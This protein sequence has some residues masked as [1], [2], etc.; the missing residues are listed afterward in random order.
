MLRDQI[1]GLGARSIRKSY[2]PQLQE[3]IDDLKKAKTALEEKS[4]S[5]LRTLNDLEAARQRAEESEQKF[6]SLFEGITDGVV[7]A[8]PET[9]QLLKVNPTFCQMLGYS[10]AELLQLTIPAI[11][12]PEELPRLMEEITKQKPGMSV[13]IKNLP[14]KRRD[15]TLVYTDIHATGIDL[16]NRH[17]VLGACRDIT[18]R[19]QAEE[20]LREREEWMRYI[21]QY[22][23]SAI[24]V[25][26]H[27]LK[28]IFVSDRFLHDYNV[29]AHDVIGKHHYAVFPELP[30]KWKVMHQRCLAGAIEKNDDDLFERPDG[31]INYNRW[32]CRPWFHASGK[33]GGIVMYTEVITERKLAEQALVKSEQKYRELVENANSIILRWTPDGIITYLNEFGLTFFGYSEK[34]IVGL[35]VS[36]IIVPE[37]ESTGR[38]LFPLMSDILADPEKFSHNINE[39]I[40]RNGERVWIA[41]TN[42][43]V[44]DNEGQIKEILS[45]GS[46]VTERIRMEEALNRE[47]EFNRA[48]VENM[49]DA[50][51]ACNAEFEL[52]LFNRAAR[53]W[54]GVDAMNIPPEQWAEFYHLFCANGVT[55]MSLED[56]PLAR[57][58]HGETLHDEPMVIQAKGQPL[59]HILANS[60]PF[61]D[62]HGRKLGAVA[63]M[64]DITERKR[65]EAELYRLNRLYAVLSQ[66]NQAV[67]HAGSQHELLEQICRIA[68]EFGAFKMAWV[69]KINPDTQQ[70]IPVAVAGD[71]GGYLDGIRVFADDRPEGRGPIGTSIREERTYVSNDFHSDPSTL[72]WR[73]AANRVGFRAI[74]S[75]PLKHEEKIFG[76][77]AVYAEEPDCFHAKEIKLLEEV[78]SDVSFALDLLSREM[79]RQ[80]NEVALQQAKE[81]AEAASRAK[82]QFIAV[83]SHELRTPLTPVLTTVTLLQAHEELSEEI[84]TE[85][86]I[87]RRNVQLEAKL[88]DDLLDVTRISRGIVE[89]HLEEVDAHAC[90]MKTLEICQSEIVAK[91]L[92][93]SWKLRAKAYHVWADSARL[94]QV[95]WNLLKNA[96]KFTP[97]EGHIYIRTSN[98]GTRL[99]IEVADAGIGIEPEVLPRIFNAF[100]QGEQTKTRRFGG[101]GLGLSIAKAVVELHHGSLTAHSDGHNKGSIFTVEL[102]TIDATPR[103]PSERIAPLPHKKKPCKILLVEDHPDTLRILCRLLKKWGYTVQCAEGVAEALNLAASEPF[104]LL[105]SDLGLPDGSGLDI[106]AQT[107]ERYGLR[108]I[109]LSGFGTD[110]DLRRSRAAGFEEH[111]TKPVGI[112]S[113]RTAVERVLAVSGDGDE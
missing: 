30:E 57:A 46:D 15:G 49:L 1:I 6:R 102:E 23:P 101:L 59:R 89:L 10:E 27:N 90:L 85:M 19:R 44:L 103:V 48:L 81:T 95:F 9:K 2:Y 83:L 3:Q 54:H 75:L 26:D 28:Y 42:K 69:G 108:G 32:E 110:D 77:L 113:L 21:I 86:E 87:I 7:V 14:F 12:P 70:V 63:V 97:E 22:D 106:M 37:E 61:F 13:L 65:A 88:I 52:T 82:D 45:I 29:E 71:K 34:E 112:E 39:N 104:D 25:L 31:S 111:L 50:V 68:V 93:V 64:H 109:A 58:F 24:A 73:E 72:P 38:K 62:E 80:Q 17:C 100:E 41:W 47:Q 43:V 35:P 8:D 67:I 105:I 5:L 60:A 55:P 56:V 11:H 84:R 51:V 4:E 66:V 98:T 99:K 18:E 53:E 96:V 91:S 36:G 74:I 33:I 92:E 76:A 107:K 16:E 79:R 94:Q 78:A 20:Q 40:R